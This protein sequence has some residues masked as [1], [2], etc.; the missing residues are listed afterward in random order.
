MESHH[1]LAKT[2]TIQ[3]AAK[4]VSTLLGLIAT[5]LMLRLLGPERLGWYTIASGY[6]QFIGIAG[7]FGFML[8][9]STMLSEPAFD[10]TKVFNTMFSWR[11]I[12]A[13]VLQGLA[14]LGF[15]LFSYRQP[16]PTAVAILSVSFFAVQLNQIFAGYFQAKLQN[17]I[18]L[19]G[20]VLS[21]I[22]LLV[23]LLAFQQQFDVRWAGESLFLPLVWLITGASVA[24]SIYLFIRHG[25]FKLELDRAIS[26]ALF[27]KTWPT[28][29]CIIFN[30]IYL[31]GDKVILPLYEKSAY[32]VGLYGASYR[33][34]DIITQIAAMLMATL[35]PLLTF[36]WSRG[37]KKEF[38]GYVQLSIEIMALLLLPMVGGLI[39]L[40]TPIMSF[41]GPAYS[42]GGPLL[43]W[44]SLAIIGIWLGTT[45][46]HIA[47][48]I[49]RQRQA[50][51]IF[52][53]VA[54][55]SLAGYFY[56]IPRNGLWGAVGVSVA[57]EALAG[58]ALSLLVWKY[59]SIKLSFGRLS[60]IFLAAALMTALVYRLP[61]HN[62]AARILAGAAIY[63]SFLYMFQ[64]ITPSIVRDF[65]K[66][67]KKPLIAN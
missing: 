22:I 21:R 43:S 26:R 55:L 8:V 37:L 6:L 29:L 64:V 62:L 1:H 31:Q 45:F 25:F 34:I 61:I 20:E 54:V 14:P 30:A 4:L 27:T 33:V 59:S 32:L 47:L 39:A 18:P 40:G 49:N 41:V 38:E 60:N 35:L 67:F 5:L 42:G 66:T 13:V 24:N 65:L 36:H 63:L 16:I 7:D 52:A 56:F 2:T 17:H 51:Y 50:T 12:T 58:G 15:L 46:G 57:A 19:I 28:A 3:L 23:G 9:T 10:K 53:G 48:A 11:L 44:L